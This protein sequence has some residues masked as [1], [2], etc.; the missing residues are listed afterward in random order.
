MPIYEYRCKRG[1][2][3]ENI[4]LDHGAHST[5]TCPSCGSD[6]PK[7]P[8]RTAPFVM[9]TEQRQDMVQQ[10]IGFR[11]RSMRALNHE[12][13]RRGLLDLT[14]TEFKNLPRKEQGDSSIPAERYMSAFAD[15]RQKLESDD[16]RQR[17]LRLIEDSNRNAP[18]INVLENAG[19]IVPFKEA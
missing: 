16:Y 13:D 10:H 1:H 15:A 8:S 5:A 2:K 7:L 14:P 4:Y 19:K 18:P 3:F 17:A 9:L 12:L 11:P 6:A